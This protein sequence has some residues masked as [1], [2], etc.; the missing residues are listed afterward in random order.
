L[1]DAW[2]AVTGS[3]YLIMETSK[4]GYVKTADNDAAAFPSA[5]YKNWR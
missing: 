5:G 4:L 1:K 3:D 2:S